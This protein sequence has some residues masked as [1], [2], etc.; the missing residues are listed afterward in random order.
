MGG[1]AGLY[2]Y[3]IRCICLS[4]GVFDFRG[5]KMIDLLQEG[6]RVWVDVV[7][8]F[9]EVGVLRSAPAELRMF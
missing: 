1:L 6:W 4:N 3:S 8:R 7:I 9:W 5:G 2:R